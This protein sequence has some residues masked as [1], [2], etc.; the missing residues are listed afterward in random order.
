MTMRAAMLILS[1]MATTAGAETAMTT[2]MSLAEFEAFSTGKTLVYA[3]GGTVIG[4]EQHL[5]GN[6]TLDADLGGPCTEG[7]WFADGEAICFVYAAYPGTHC[8]LFWREG[9]GVMARTAGAQTAEADGPI[10]SVTAS[11]APLDCL[12]DVGV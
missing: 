5:P 9:G 7:E 11:D 10:Y 4:S 6:R 3:E 12:P 8:W 2:P 1:L